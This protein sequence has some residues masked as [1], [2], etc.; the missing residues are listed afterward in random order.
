MK[1]HRKPSGLAPQQLAVRCASMR[2]KTVGN[3]KNSPTIPTVKK[4]SYS[5]VSE[6]ENDRWHSSTATPCWATSVGG[7]AAYDTA[8]A[9]AI[10]M[11]CVRCLVM[12][13]YSMNS[14]G[15]ESTVRAGVMYRRRNVRRCCTVLLTGAKARPPKTRQPT[16][17]P[18]V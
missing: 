5:I 8:R 2:M 10:G 9:R 18:M 12:R 15:S 11:H 7:G 17:S 14:V 13:E 4:C 1:A 16:A 3:R 6:Q